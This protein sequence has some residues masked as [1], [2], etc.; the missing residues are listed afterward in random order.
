MVA[1]LAAS[2][3]ELNL[4]REAKKSLEILSEQREQ[5]ASMCPADRGYLSRPY[6]SLSSDHIMGPSAANMKERNVEEGKR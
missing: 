4:R 1:A 3:Y 6:G 5:C 2:Q